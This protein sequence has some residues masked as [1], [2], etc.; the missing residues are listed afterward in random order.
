MSKASAKER[1][2]KLIAAK[3][4]FSLC[5]R[6]NLNNGVLPAQRQM[7]LKDRMFTVCYFIELFKKEP[8]NGVDIVFFHLPKSQIY[9]DKK[10]NI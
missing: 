10:E 6:K 4:I 3:F 2:H 5:S 1:K 8:S 9:F 7:S